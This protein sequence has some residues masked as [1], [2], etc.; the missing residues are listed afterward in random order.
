M[1]VYGSRNM[2]RG[3]CLQGR[4]GGADVEN[5]LWPQSRKH[6]VRGTG[7]AGLYIYIYIYALTLFNLPTCCHSSAFSAREGMIFLILKKVQEQKIPKGFR[8]NKG[9]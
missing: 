2:Y 4:N 1:H 9:A 6:R 5:R 3:A 8:K 7:R